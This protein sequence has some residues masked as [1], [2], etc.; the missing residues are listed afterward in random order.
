MSKRNS[1][2][3][4]NYL[5]KRRMMSL[6]VKASSMVL[7]FPRFWPNLKFVARRYELTSLHCMSL[8]YCYRH[9]ASGCHRC[10]KHKQSTTHRSKHASRHNISS[11]YTGTP[12]TESDNAWNSL[13]QPLYFNASANELAKTI[14]SLLQK[15]AVKV[16]KGGYLASFEVYHQLHCLKQLRRWIYDE[17][18]R[19]VLA[20]AESN[21]LQDHLGH[22]IERLRA[23][24]ICNP[25]LQ[26]NFFTWRD[27]GLSSAKLS[28]PFESVLQSQ[29]C[30]N[31][32]L[33]NAWAQGRSIS[34]APKLLRP[35]NANLIGPIM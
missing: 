34:I 1:M 3:A 30:V 32:D 25:S 26:V 33:V 2:R 4:N 20:P 18:F 22:C 24:L 15:D 31:W 13:I 23:F 9:G 17:D 21:F 7:I 10:S 14:P 16:L 29:K 19:T 35:S 5:T 6:P 8:C 27:E 28:K 12:T 11:I